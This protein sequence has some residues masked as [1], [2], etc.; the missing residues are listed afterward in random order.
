[1]KV[2]FWFVLA[3][4]I[5]CCKCVFQGRAAR[6][7]GTIETSD[8]QGHVLFRV[9]CQQSTYNAPRIGRHFGG[10]NENISNCD[11]NWGFVASMQFLRVAKDGNRGARFTSGIQTDSDGEG[12]YGF[13]G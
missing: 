8:H 2:S 13:D 7:T 11:F 6:G 12:H 5:W 1:M 4:F 3:G 9:V 10:L